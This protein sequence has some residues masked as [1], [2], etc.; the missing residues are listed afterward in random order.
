MSQSFLLLVWLKLSG[1][2]MSKS[3]ILK[4]APACYLEFP[5]IFLEL[6]DELSQTETKGPGP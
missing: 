4:D 5:D 2:Q 1:N 3:S 6:G